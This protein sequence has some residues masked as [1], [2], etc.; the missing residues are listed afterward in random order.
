MSNIVVVHS[1]LSMCLVLRLEC[2]QQQLRESLMKDQI[3]ESV[4]TLCLPEEGRPEA[5]SSYVILLR[6]KGIS[7][8]YLRYVSL[9]HFLPEE[10]GIDDTSREEQRRFLSYLGN[11]LS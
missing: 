4:C 7:P 8:W 9:D 10:T 3:P 5:G 1:V 11:I 2:L 6:K